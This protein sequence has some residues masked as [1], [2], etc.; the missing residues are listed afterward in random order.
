M[1]NL[2][3]TLP[4][5]GQASEIKCLIIMTE[6]QCKK[7]ATCFNQAVAWE[8]RTAGPPRVLCREHASASKARIIP[9]WGE[10]DLSPDSEQSEQ[11]TPAEYRAWGKANGWEIGERGRIP[12]DLRK[13]YHE[14]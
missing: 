8:Y 14:Q 5:F 1:E 7:S 2:I 12:T 9:F 6:Q 11:A 10:L 13:A 3:R 4:L